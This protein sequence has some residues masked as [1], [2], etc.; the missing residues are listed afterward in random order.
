MKKVYIHYV[1]TF[2]ALASNYLNLNHSPPNVFE[3]LRCT[4]TANNDIP[5][6]ETA[7]PVHEPFGSCCSGLMPGRSPF[8]RL[9]FLVSSHPFCT[10]QSMDIYVFCYS[11]HPMQ[12]NVLP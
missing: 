2:S 4:M 12:Y 6:V 3:D 7:R 11:L 9:I 5:D 8:Q 10:D 1:R